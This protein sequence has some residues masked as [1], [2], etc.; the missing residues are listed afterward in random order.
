MNIWEKQRKNNGL[1]RFEMAKAMGISE[2]KIEQIE[3]GV[4]EMPTEKVDEYLEKMRNLSKTERKLKA[5]EARVWYE[6]ADLKKLISDFGFKNQREF[7]RAIGCEQSSISIWANKKKKIG[8]PALLKL[9]YFFNDGFNKVVETP[10]KAENSMVDDISKYCKDLRE[11]YD[12]TDFIELLREKNLTQ[13]DISREFDIP[14]STLNNWVKKTSI[15]KRGIETLYS[16]FGNAEQKSIK[17]NVD[18]TSK[19]LEEEPTPMFTNYYQ[20]LEE[21]TTP[22]CTISTT[23]DTP[24]EEDTTKEDLCR[25]KEENE[26]LR[27]QIA[28]YELLIDMAM[29]GE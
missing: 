28:R 23:I 16:I 7:A 10:T 3:S 20:G 2:E 5:A 17:V 15:T 13:K 25:L 8:T 6:N 1:T 27:K 4:R 18:N 21:D 24:M 26:R 12:K 14:F 11:W 22:T 9:Y 29:K 19:V